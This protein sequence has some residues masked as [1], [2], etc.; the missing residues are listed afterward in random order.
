MRQNTMRLIAALIGA[1]AV[2]SALAQQAGKLDFVQ[3]SA[4]VVAG[5]GTRR[6]AQSGSAL[7]VGESVET[8]DDGRFQGDH[9]LSGHRLS[10]DHR[11][12]G[13]RI[14]GDSALSS[15]RPGPEQAEAQHDDQRG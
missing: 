7:A 9:R 12:T 4:T 2:S 1:C 8:G 14:G 6:Q 11:L 13:R 3:G 15:R 10:G 5:D